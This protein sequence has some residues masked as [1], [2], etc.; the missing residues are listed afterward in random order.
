MTIDCQLRRMQ[1][2]VLCLLMLLIV[3]G[4]LCYTGEMM[5]GLYG[6][7]QKQLQVLKHALA[8]NDRW[9]FVWS[10][11]LNPNAPGLHQPDVEF[12]GKLIPE[13]AEIGPIDTFAVVKKIVD[14]CW[15]SGMY[16]SYGLNLLARSAR[17]F[18]HRHVR[19]QLAAIAVMLTDTDREILRRYL[20]EVVKDY[21]LVAD[22]LA[23]VESS[24][25]HVIQMVTFYNDV[26]NVK[27][28]TNVPKAL[29]KIRKIVEADFQKYCAVPV[30][31][32]WY[33]EETN[34][35]V[36]MAEI[37]EE[38]VRT[39]SVPQDDP[40]SAIAS[41]SDA[42]S[43]IENLRSIMRRTFDGLLIE[44]MSPTIWEDI[45]N[46]HILM[47]PIDLQKVALNKPRNIPVAIGRPF[48]W[49]R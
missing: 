32:K 22:K 8:H 43:R 27:D 47:K 25:K 38:D 7:Y 6:N 13:G 36:D 15:F 42:P 26:I 18:L 11:K 5:D 17:C 12:C 10:E 35:L 4:G 45:F 21:R 16:V 20:L 44:Q 14:S 40:S 48:P 23:A 34:T 37:R 29:K 1:T 2:S 9:S 3:R 49:K 46:N 39:A 19:L 24:L 31:E 33:D 28:L 30:T 41:S